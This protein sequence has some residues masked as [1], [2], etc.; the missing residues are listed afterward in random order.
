MKKH[1]I[2]FLLCWIA[3]F[4]TYIGRQNYTASMSEIIA[5][6]GYLN[7]TCGLVGTGF[8]IT[9][10][11]GQIISGFLG[12]RF[13]PKWMIF[14][15]I[16]L[17]SL[18]NLSMC[19]LTSPEAM[20]AVWCLNGAAQSMTWSPLLR[21]FSEYLPQEEQK[22]ACVNIA[23][24]YPAAVFLIYP[25]CSFLIYV[26]GWRMVFLVSGGFMLAVS[27]LWALGFTRLEGLYPE[28]ERSCSRKS[29]DQCGTNAQDF[30]VTGNLI[31]LLSLAGF[32]L[33]IQG[34]L[35]DGVTGWVPSYLSNTYEVG[36]FIAIFATTFLPFINLFGVYFANLIYRKGKKNELETTVI[37]FVISFFSILFLIIFEGV[38]LVLSLVFFAVTTSCMMGINVMLVSFIPSYF[39]RFGKVSTISGLLNST[40]YIGSSLAVYGLGALADS[41]GWSFILKFLCMVA[42]AGILG[43]LICVPRWGKFLR[44]NR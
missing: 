4:S 20:T 27:L 21:I 33:T 30:R 37:L 16:F 3:Y 11:L 25:L 38:S 26:S 1:R 7:R 31:L 15:G 12:D 35:R 23:T 36:T 14:T 43:S 19:F 8:F 40:V 10:G 41:V 6:E 34:A 17:S 13:S 42:A 5:A 18:S 39:I 29:M 22:T 2:L 9:Y 44:E 28:R 24:T 32:L